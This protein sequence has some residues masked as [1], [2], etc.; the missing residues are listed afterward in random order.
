MGGSEYY[1]YVHGITGGQ[2]PKVHLEIDRQN[3]KAVLNLTKSGIVTCAH[4]CS[5]G[6]LGVALAEMAIAGST[7]FR[8]NLAAIPNSCERIDD[9]L[10]SESHSRYIIGTKEPDKV[11]RALS[12]AGVTFSEIG[13]TAARL[14][15]ANG[16]KNVIRLTLNQLKNSFDS[17]GKVMR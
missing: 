2:V 5:K 1:E 6:G 17:L 10:F 15:F 12:S 11:H 3:G 7:G 8:V 16:K 14:D 13:N 9:L 4:D